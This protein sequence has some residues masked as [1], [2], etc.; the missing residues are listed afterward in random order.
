MSKNTKKT[1][2]DVASKAAKVLT[3]PNAS[4]TAKKIS[5]ICAISERDD[6]TNRS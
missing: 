6:Q 2:K 1:S 5:G 3:D 4:K